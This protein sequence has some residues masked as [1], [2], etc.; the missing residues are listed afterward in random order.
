MSKFH[1]IAIVTTKST[2]RQ[3]IRP[4]AA[5]TEFDEMTGE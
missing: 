1:T 3:V 2:T 4:S 5:R